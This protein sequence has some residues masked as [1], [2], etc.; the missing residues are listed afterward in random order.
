M[1]GS[2]ESSVRLYSYNGFRTVFFFFVGGG[3]RLGFRLYDMGSRGDVR[4]W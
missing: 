4:K 1:N 3:G 2:T